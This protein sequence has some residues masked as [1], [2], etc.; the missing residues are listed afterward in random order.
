MKAATEIQRTDP[1][2][3][4][5]ASVALALVASGWMAG[6]IVD[7]FSAASSLSLSVEWRVNIGAGLFLG[8]TFSNIVGAT[9]ARSHFRRAGIRFAIGFVLGVVT[10]FAI[11]TPF[12]GHG[13]SNFLFLLLAGSMVP[14]VLMVD[15]IRVF[16]D[17]NDIVPAES[18]ANM[19]IRVLSW[20]T[21][22]LFV[23]M[24]GITFALFWA[25]ASNIGQVL[26]VLAGVLLMLTLSVSL[27][28]VEEEDEN[29]N[30]EELERRIWLALV[31]ED[32]VYVG[33]VDQAAGMLRNLLLN[34][35]P[36][37]VLFGGM[38]RLAIEF[39]RVVYP[40]IQ[41]NFS[42][43]L[44]LMQTAGVVAVSGLAVV[45]FGMMTALGICLMVLRI[46]GYVK[47][48]SY[49]HRRENYV[50]LIR[51]MYFRPMKRM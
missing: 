21:R 24:M 5:F 31:P 3:G 40:N 33:V 46:I 10:Q 44:S 30:P 18:L 15:Q 7:L 29:E 23:L 48:W 43:P 32:V 35:M 22:F 51:L 12:A 26:T 8:I 25:Y 19:V 6:M 9:I 1:F 45:F 2:V 37:A 38:I 11:F 16:L 39:L 42:D 50:H 49:G 27:R 14:V 47:N 17:K 13:M 36:A 28:E 4:Y 34:L 41:A 20:P